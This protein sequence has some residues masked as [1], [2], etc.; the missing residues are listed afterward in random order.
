MICLYPV[1]VDLGDVKQTVACGRC[2]HCRIT[3]NQHWSLRCIL[4]SK[5]HRDNTFLTLTYSDEFLPPGGS[6][7]PEDVTLWLKRFRVVLARQYGVK[8][9]YFLVGEYGERKGR[10]HYHL[11]V[12][13][14][15]AAL[16]EAVSLQTWKMGRV[17]SLPFE[18]GAAG[19]VAQYTLKKM[20]KED[21]ERL[22]GRHPEYARQ[23]RNPGLGQKY[24]RQRLIPILKRNPNFI[25]NN[26]LRIHGKKYP[27]DRYIR[28]E[29]IDG[30]ELEKPNVHTKALVKS[31]RRWQDVIDGKAQTAEELQKERDEARQRL[32]TWFRRKARKAPEGVA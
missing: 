30:L 10:P 28:N 5:T 14:A 18:K 27:L 31:L 32:R 8:I 26:T 9:R 12:F 4:E 19:Y 15:D 21:D 29:L 16:V 6:L 1:T 3:K 22:A 24:I 7:K 25:H 20:T 11:I 2:A 17:K 23:S 13:G